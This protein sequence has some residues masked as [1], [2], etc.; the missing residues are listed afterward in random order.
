MKDI[1]RELMNYLI[2][3]FNMESTNLVK[4]KITIGAHLINKLKHGINPLRNR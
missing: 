3:L 1:S 2:R 4:I